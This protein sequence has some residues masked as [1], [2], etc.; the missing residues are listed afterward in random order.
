MCVCLRWSVGRRFPEKSW[1]RKRG[2]KMC[3]E[4]NLTGTSSDSSTWHSRTR[5][6]IFQWE[7]QRLPQ[8]LHTQISILLS[9]L[10][11][12]IHTTLG[13]MLAILWLT[14][15]CGT[16]GTI[17]DL[18]YK[19][20]SSLSLFL[21]FQKLSSCQLEA[22]SWQHCLKLFKSMTFKLKITENFLW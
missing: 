15:P 12:T 9:Y 8:Q 4:T 19:E 11:S 7:L 1:L 21:T 5:F 2:V 20:R 16:F 14:H 13:H 6:R 10:C 17:I 18:Y 3:L 22:V